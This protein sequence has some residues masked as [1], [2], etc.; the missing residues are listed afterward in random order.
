MEIEFQDARTWAFSKRPPRSIRTVRTYIHSGII[1]LVDGEGNVVAKKGWRGQW[2]I[3]K[4]WKWPGV[5]KGGARVG[6]GRK[7]R[8]SIEYV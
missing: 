4:D 6:A 8:K 1:P 5:G 7:S 3:R 2:F